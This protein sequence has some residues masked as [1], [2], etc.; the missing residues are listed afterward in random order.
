MEIFNRALNAEE[1]RAIYDAGSAGKI[2]PRRW[3]AVSN[4]PVAAWSAALL[5]TG[6]VLLF[7]NGDSMALFDPETRQFSAGVSSNTNL[8]CAGLAWLADG[9]LLA[10][11]GHAAE[12]PPGHFL[13]L[14]S[15]EIFDP[16]E[17]QWTRIPDMAGG[18]RWYPTAVTLPD[19]RV[20]VTAGIHAG[21]ANMTSEILDLQ[22]VEWNVVANQQPLYFPDLYPWAAGY[23]SRGGALLRTSTASGTL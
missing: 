20:L 13:G 9:R 6:K 17:E 4:V 8:F 1:I 2:K 19:E 15:A 16:W 11:G 21:E 10:V 22:R 23:T 12:D 3:S 5:P 7:Q 18:E 14:K